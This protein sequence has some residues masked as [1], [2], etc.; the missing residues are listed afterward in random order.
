M[1]CARIVA[2]PCWPFEISP[3][4]ELYSGLVLNN[5]YTRSYILMIFSIN[6]Y[7]VKTVCHI[8]KWLLHYADLLCYL[9]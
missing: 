1:A 8:Q 7:Q 6:V 3:L 4:N 2:L 9:P 5:S